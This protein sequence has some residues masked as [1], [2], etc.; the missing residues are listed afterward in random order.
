MRRIDYFKGNNYPDGI[1]AIVKGR[2]IS[3]TLF[4]KAI[5]VNSDLRKQIKDTIDL[6][7]CEYAFR[8]NSEIIQAAKE[9]AEL[10]STEILMKFLNG[11]ENYQLLKRLV[12]RNRIIRLLAMKDAIEQK[13]ML[14][15]VKEL[16][17]V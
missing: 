7:L 6:G 9:R 11:M 14:C 16:K 3:F 5:K 15:R 12:H 17:V 2:K 1:C 4:Q 10:Q 8:V 13:E